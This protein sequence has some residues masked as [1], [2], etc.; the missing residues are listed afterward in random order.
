ME[1]VIQE[2]ENDGIPPK[3]S[4]GGDMEEDMEDMEEDEEATERQ[5]EWDG[6]ADDG[7]AQGSNDV[8]MN[9]V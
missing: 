3:G 9:D 7:A 5:L 1:C 6:Q 2:L 8:P 4:F